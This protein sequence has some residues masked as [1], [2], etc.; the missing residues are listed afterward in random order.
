MKVIQELYL[1]RPSD[2]SSF[3]RRPYLLNSADKHSAGARYRIPV[4]TLLFYYI[5][6]DFRY[7]LFISAAC[8]SICVK[9]A[10]SMFKVCTSISISLS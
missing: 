6:H 8:P 2:R 4:L 5:Q 3:Q 9:L 10:E 1:F 7:L